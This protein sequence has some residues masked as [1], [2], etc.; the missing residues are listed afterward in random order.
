MT[1]SRAVIEVRD[2]VKTFPGD[3][4][5]GAALL[6][7]LGR[8][9]ERRMALSDVTVDIAR[10]GV[11]GL[12]GPNGAGKTTLLKLIATLFLP[13]S[14]SIRVDGL[15][16]VAQALEVKRRIGLCPNE[17]RSFYLRL[18]A[19]RNLEFFGTLLGLSRAKLARRIGEVA[20]TVDLASVIDRPF[21][22][23][24]SGMRQRLAIARAM[25]GEPEVYIFDEPTRAVDPVHA[26]EIRRLLRDHVAHTLGK[27]V[28]VST[29][30]LEEAWSICDDVAILANG[31]LVAHGTPGEL[32]A[33]FVAR[34][35]FAIALRRPDD[36]LFERLR[37]LDGVA[38]V[39]VH[40]GESEPE[41]TIALDEV[42]DNL[43]R[44]FGVLA[45][46][47]GV[48]RGFRQLGEEPFEVFAAATG[49]GSHA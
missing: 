34:K 48:V 40:D 21:R 28:I 1:P 38:I 32:A 7:R 3:Y 35:H 2:V 41:I 45:G 10:G 37:A 24:S 43:S 19:R 39:E 47:D 22:T 31:R 16:V 6:S 11:F 8:R 15:D 49:A 18:S 17:D 25:L 26:G 4:R 46:G 27:T 29:N 30:V 36:A 20:N 12:V 14:G 5:V 13:D 42:G 33:R 23:L 44:L 9:A